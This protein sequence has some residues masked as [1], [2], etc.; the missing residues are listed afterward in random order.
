MA[1]LVRFKWH[2]FGSKESSYLH[3]DRLPTLDFSSS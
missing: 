3:P 1:A 2:L